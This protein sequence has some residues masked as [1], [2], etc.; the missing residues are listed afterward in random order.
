[1]MEAL[2]WIGVALAV[3]VFWFA[4]R[5]CQA[6]AEMDRAFDE[7]DQELDRRAKK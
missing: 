4:V 6:A 3:L 2:I 5:M 1:M 7:L